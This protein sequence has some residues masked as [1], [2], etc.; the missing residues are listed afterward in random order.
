MATTPPVVQTTAAR[1]GDLTPVEVLLAAAAAENL[2]ELLAA[3]VALMRCRHGGITAP[4]ITSAGHHL[5]GSPSHRPPSSPT[6]V[7]ERFTRVTARQVTEA[8]A[9]GELVLLEQPC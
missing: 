1:A 3:R 8:V 2:D 4:L 9:G 6:R 5:L 7:S